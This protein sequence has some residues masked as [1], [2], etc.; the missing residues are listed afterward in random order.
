MLRHFTGFYKQ[1]LKKL[2]LSAY[3]LMYASDLSPL[4]SVCPACSAKG[5]LSP[6]ASYER[7][8][9]IYADGVHY[10]RMRIVRHLCGCGRT[11]AVLPELIIPYRTYSILFILMVLKAYHFRSMNGETVVG[12]AER[13]EIAVST[14]YR[15]K[16]CF[17]E[18][19]RLWLGLL[20]AAIK[21]VEEFFAVL[22][23]GPRYLS[24][25][26]ACFFLRFGFSFLGSRIDTS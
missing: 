26:L 10:E 2:N 22:C 14:L 18:H 1:D 7:G 11:H 3:I 15:W 9:A 8:I 21:A 19:R 24:E 17:E 20:D 16:A 13:Y 6:H 25:E 12:I 23:R 4:A 5:S